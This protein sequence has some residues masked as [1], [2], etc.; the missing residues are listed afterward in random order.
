MEVWLA[1]ADSAPAAIFDIRRNSGGGVQPHC[2]KESAPLA[3]KSLRQK[4][5]TRDYQTNL[6]SR[7]A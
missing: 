1:G 7:K 2:T 4:H 3:R 5:E 6:A